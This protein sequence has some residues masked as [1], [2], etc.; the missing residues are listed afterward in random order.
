METKNGKPVMNREYTI[1]QKKLSFQQRSKIIDI[2]QISMILI[3]YSSEQALPWRVS[4]IR[5]LKRYKYDNE[6]IFNLHLNKSTKKMDNFP[7]LHNFDKNNS[8]NILK[9]TMR[10]WVMYKRKLDAK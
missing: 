10:K 2:F 9:Y 1:L 7:C 8:S 6:K 4:N 3:D 5:H